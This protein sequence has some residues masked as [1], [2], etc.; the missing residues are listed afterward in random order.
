M[1]SVLVIVDM[2]NDFI[3]GSLANDAALKII[4]NIKAEVESGKY[5]C[6]IFTRD[7][8]FDN[9]LETQEGKNLPVNHCI[10]NTW[11][12]EICDELNFANFNKAKV[13]YLQKDSFGSN[14]WKSFL[15][16]N[17]IEQTAKIT[18]VGTCTDICVVSNVLC[19]KA[20]FPEAQI[21][22]IESCCAPL[23]GSKAKQDA[24]LEIMK[25]C[26]ISVI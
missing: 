13:F 18:F 6:I 1:K 22:C 21:M 16:S 10:E 14:Q 19:V 2:Q 23:M 4:P 11:G 12:W 9:Y 26:Q 24:A 20:A 7:T 25:S 5:E 8:H 3:T 15:E 17:E